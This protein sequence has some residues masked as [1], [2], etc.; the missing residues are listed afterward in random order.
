MQTV[1]F[2]PVR[3]EQLQNVK[4]SSAKTSRKQ[5]SADCNGTSFLYGAYSSK[6][7]LVS[8]VDSGSYST[9]VSSGPSSYTGSAFVSGPASGNGHSARTAMGT[10]KT[11]AFVAKNAL[12]APDSAT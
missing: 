8:G 6:T 11:E 4:S 1:R 7:A 5:K 9:S 3:S 10:A 12:N 2:P